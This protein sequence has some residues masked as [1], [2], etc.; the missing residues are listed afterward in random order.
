MPDADGAREALVVAADAYGDARLRALRAPAQ[1]A[2][3][4][5]RVLGDPG[6]GDFRVS[7]SLNE[8]DHAVRRKIS[9]FFHDRGRDDLL[10]LHISC[11]G[12]KDED[13]TLYFA[14]S[15]TEVD[16]LDATAVPSEFVNRAM[17]RSRSRRIV[18]LLDCCFGGAFA[19]GL[20]HRAG[21][22]VAIREEFE[23]QGR[24]VHR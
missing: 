14:S 9:D 2:Q 8:P 1:D 21:D 10:L 4:L 7:V 22:A 20:V 17:T 12:L 18:L 19:R 15:N 6:I 24:V 11:H 13:G 23:G 3:E 16:H 5:A